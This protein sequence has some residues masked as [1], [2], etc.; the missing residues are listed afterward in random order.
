MTAR[1]RRTPG[2]VL[3]AALLLAGCAAAPPTPAPPP[4]GSAA[5]AALPAVYGAEGALPP[6]RAKQVLQR[7]QREGQSDLLARHLRV[8]EGLI[9]A[10]LRVGNS[11]ELLIDGP[12]T[13]RAMYAAI[14]AAR[15]NVNLETYILEADATG[16]RFADL[17][18]RKRRQ[19]V[20]VNV[21]YDAVGS[22]QTPRAYF[23]GLREAGVRVCEYNP[24]N[25]LEAPRGWR[26][27]NRDHRKILVVDGRTGFTGG[28]N[29][30]STYSSSSFRRR[31]KPP[32][33]DGW[34][35]THVQV[36]GPAVHDLQRLFVDTW[37]EQC[38][39]FS[40]DGY[41]PKVEPAGSEVVRVIAGAPGDNEVYAAM[42]SAI[43]CAQISVHLT[44]GY[45]VPDP[46]TLSALESA[47]Q[48]GVDVQLALPGVSDFWAPLHAGRS[49][50]TRL[51]NSG[52]RIYERRDALL[53][54]K[55]GVIDGV[56]STVGSTNLDWRSFVH[57]A[58]ANVEI[59]DA[60]FA[61]RM[62]ELFRFDVEHS[63][64]ITASDW[65]A[66]GIGARVKEWF[67]RQWEYLL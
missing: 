21:I 48:R 11:V 34:R 60:G 18:T 50:Y 39:A 45:F 27:N 32:V 9:E 61:E 16:S 35:D 7:L 2:Q 15:H 46:R 28:I 65:N 44:I 17:L 41:F 64:E 30:S 26:I 51:L 59:L 47:A 49:H 10:P 53:H 25:P 13:L 12:A 62:E 22:L 5:G 43:E 14:E 38:G 55:T 24:V 29:I 8:T 33:E 6:A 42:L 23:D 52:V 31:S 3:A 63:I 56:W 58:E 57:N 37:R 54:A 1:Q 36:R 19:G 66:R 67:S 4:P 20:E 40:D